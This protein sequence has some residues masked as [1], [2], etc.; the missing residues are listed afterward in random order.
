MGATALSLAMFCLALGATARVQA[1]DDDPAASGKREYVNSCATCHGM[2]GKG[3]GPVPS[4]LKGY[5]T[6]DPSDLTTLAKRNNG[7]F[8]WEHVV[9][10]IDGRADV[11]VHGSRDMPVWGWRYRRGSGGVEN[12]TAELIARGRILNLAEYLKSMQE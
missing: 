2:D 11:K 4:L 8:P 5:L 9:R 3:E 10:V 12:P 1:A 7:Q 6:D